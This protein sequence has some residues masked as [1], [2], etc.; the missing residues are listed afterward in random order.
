MSDGV[1]DAYRASQAAM[2][3]EDR[4]GIIRR[5]SVEHLIKLFELPELNLEELYILL[6]E[7]SNHFKIEY[8]VDEYHYNLLEGKYETK[9][10]HRLSVLPKDFSRFVEHFSGDSIKSTCYQGLVYL[11]FINTDFGKAVLKE[12]L[13]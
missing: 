11:E 1:T 3:Y 9:I 13:S 4:I 6:T 7:R 10:K 12:Y 2:K 8:E 5:S